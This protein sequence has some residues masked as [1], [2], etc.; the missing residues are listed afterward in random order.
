M[1][2]SLDPSIQTGVGSILRHLNYYFT[3]GVEESLLLLVFDRLCERSSFLM[4]CQCSIASIGLQCKSSLE[5]SDATHTLFYTL[6]HRLMLFYPMDLI[7]TFSW[8]KTFSRCR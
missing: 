5:H 3:T 1:V 4:S 8:G 7:V 2:P 6:D